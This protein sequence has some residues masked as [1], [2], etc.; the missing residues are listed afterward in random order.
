MNISKTA[1]LQVEARIKCLHKVSCLTGG[2]SNYP[3]YTGAVYIIVHIV[4]YFLHRIIII[5][6]KIRQLLLGSTMRTPADK[7]KIQ[8]GIRVF[9]DS[10][11]PPVFSLNGQ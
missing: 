8:F 9:Y 11:E 6:I 7:N 2:G 3:Y 4:I 5:I 10:T 1:P